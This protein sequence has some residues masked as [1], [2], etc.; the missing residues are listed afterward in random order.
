[1][2]GRATHERRAL[3]GQGAAGR[4]VTLKL[5]RGR[6]V[7]AAIKNYFEE[8]RMVWIRLDDSQERRIVIPGDATEIV[9]R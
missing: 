8:R 1:M 9:Q 3:L 6:A 7:E 5:A 4:R 2:P